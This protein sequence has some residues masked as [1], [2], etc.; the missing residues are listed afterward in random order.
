M[1]VEPGHGFQHSVLFSQGDAEKGRFPRVIRLPP[2]QGL[3]HTTLLVDNR[4]QRTDDRTN[5]ESRAGFRLEILSLNPG[6]YDVRWRILAAPEKGRRTL[7]SITATNSKQREWL[8]CRGAGVTLP[9][10]IF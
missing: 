8:F 4:A 3:G 7:N 1:E 10:C 6:H 5:F 9:A 2:L